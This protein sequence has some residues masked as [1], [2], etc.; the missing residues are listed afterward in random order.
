MITINPY[1]YHNFSFRNIKL[2]IINKNNRI[3]IMIGGYG[4]PLDFIYPIF[5]FLLNTVS[6]FKSLKENKTVVCKYKLYVSHRIEKWRLN[7]L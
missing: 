7:A 2:N 4:N 3:I 6:Y 1:L 5:M